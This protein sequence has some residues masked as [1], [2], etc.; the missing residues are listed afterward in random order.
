MAGLAKRLR[1]CRI[2]SSETIL[3]TV[4]L[5]ISNQNADVVSGL[6]LNIFDLFLAIL[7]LLLIV[8]TSFVGK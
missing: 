2:Y 1:L 8:V 7:N 4:V 3:S 5:Y 6:L